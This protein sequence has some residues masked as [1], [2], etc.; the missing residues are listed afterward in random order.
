M[1]DEFREILHV[2]LEIPQSAGKETPIAEKQGTTEFVPDR[3]RSDMQHSDYE[4]V[5]DF[6]STA[7]FRNPTAKQG[8]RA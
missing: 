4:P 1:T 7:V 8:A 5:L 3:L 2:L 6:I